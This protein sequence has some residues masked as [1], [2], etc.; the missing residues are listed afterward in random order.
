MRRDV[1]FLEDCRS[2]FKIFQILKKERPHILHLNSPKAAGL[3]VILGRLLGIKKII[4]TVHGFTFNENRSKIQKFLIKIISWITIA[5]SHKTIILS[6][7]EYNQVSH[8]PYI[9]NRLVIIPLGIA[10]QHFKT[11]EEAR[12]I[13]ETYTNT[14]LQNKLVVGTIAELHK[15][16][17]HR[18]AI[19]AFSELKDILY[20]M[21]GDGEEKDTLKTLVQKNQSKNIYFTGMIPDASELLKAFDIFLLPSIKEGLP[22]VL[23]EASKAEVPILSTTVGGIPTLI[24]N[25]Y[26]GILIPPKNPE[27]IALSIQEMLKNP[28][29]C[30]YFSQNQYKIT[31]K[32]F[33]FNEMV[34]KTQNLYTTR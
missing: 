11:K 4:Y 7:T 12:N 25:G 21:I 33:S 9:K 3:G 23:L 5:L 26:S 13:L 1:N 14:N 17:G 22:Y 8:W 19:D 31:Q 18:Y 27:I 30:S 34:S 6:Q 16:K 32:R 29:K 20:I 10:S 15:N 2:F 24:Q 28:S